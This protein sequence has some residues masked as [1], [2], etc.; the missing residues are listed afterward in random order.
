MDLTRYTARIRDDL[1]AAAALGD[2]K[3]Q[4][5][6]EALGMRTNTVKSHAA[7]GLAA[8]RAGIGEERV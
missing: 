5:T 1:I 4:A 3:T 7:R 8:L 2:E 6:A